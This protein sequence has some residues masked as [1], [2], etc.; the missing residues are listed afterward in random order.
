MSVCKK[1]KKKV[2]RDGNLALTTVLLRTAGDGDNPPP[3]LLDFREN[4]QG[5]CPW[6]LTFDL[7]VTPV[8]ASVVLSY[9]CLNRDFKRYK[10][11]LLGGGICSLCR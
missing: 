8:V 7:S 4:Y 6:P 5:G 1:K 10:K 3:E 11:K 2:K 9:F